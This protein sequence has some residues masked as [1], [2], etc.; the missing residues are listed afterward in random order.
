MS[1]FVSCNRRI[2]NHQKPPLEN[3]HESIARAYRRS[4]RRSIVAP[5]PLASF[6]TSNPIIAVAS[7]AAL[8]VSFF[9]TIR[10]LGNEHDIFLMFHAKANELWPMYRYYKFANR[11]EYLAG[12]GTPG[13]DEKKRRIDE[14]HDRAKV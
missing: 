12:I 6:F 10:A 11:D 14:L 5:A 1:P 7:C 9:T 3:R 13:G 2:P 8:G 4:R